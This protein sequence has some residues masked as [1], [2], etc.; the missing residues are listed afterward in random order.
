MTL[1]TRGLYNFSEFGLGMHKTR[2]RSGFFLKKIHI[3][4]YYLSDQVKSGPL[5]LGRAEYPRVGRLF[6]SLLFVLANHF[7]IN[8]KPFI[9]LE[10][11]IEIVDSPHFHVQLLLSCKNFGFIIRST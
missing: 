3:W 4:P 11:N 8:I 10:Y 7:F 9:K 6:P 2:T 5:W 1:S